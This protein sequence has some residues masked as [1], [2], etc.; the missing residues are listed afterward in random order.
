MFKPLTIQTHGIVTCMVSLALLAGCSKVKPTSQDTETK[1]GG[2]TSVAPAGKAVAKQNKALVRFLNA[3]PS[4]TRYD[5]WFDDSKT[6]TNVKYQRLTPY[7][8]L[9]ATRGEFRLRA[10]GWNDTAP[11][12]TQVGRLDSGDR[13]TVVAFSDG[14]G[15]MTLDVI[16]D[17]LAPSSNGKA[18]LRVINATPNFDE[19]DV[20]RKG[21]KRPLFRELNVATATDYKDLDAATTTLE[22]REKGE[23]KPALLIPNV[24]L[25]AGKMYTIVLAGGTV[26]TPLQAITIEDEL[27]QDVALAGYSKD[28]SLSR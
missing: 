13:Y 26:S 27:T 21:D 4:G 12:A 23:N 15:N 11:T 3:D 5:L 19:V 10:S 9:P 2:Q 20:S 17:N 7:D 25:Q 24:K 8:E 14:E 6:Y 18:R 22:V 1:A 28:L 16:S